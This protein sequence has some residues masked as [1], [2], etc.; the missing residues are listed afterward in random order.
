MT[1][2][3]EYSKNGKSCRAYAILG[4]NFCYFHDPSIAKNQA[5]ARKRGGFNRRVIKRAQQ[6]HYQ[7]KTVKDVNEILEV[8]INE[9]C[10]LESSQSQ[11][12]TLAYLCQIALKGQELGS[13]EDRIA[14]LEKSIKE[15]GNKSSVKRNEL[16]S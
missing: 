3:C 15:V 11:L 5:E 4:S 10:A 6:E 12:R 8:A 16:K 13:F 7:I 2:Q 9:A 14:S 1:V